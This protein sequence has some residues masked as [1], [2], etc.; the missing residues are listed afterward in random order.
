MRWKVKSPAMDKTQR[1]SQRLGELEREYRAL[2]TKALTECAGGRWG[3]FG[4]NEHVLRLEPPELAE[5]R[6]L[7]ET[8]NRVRARIGEPPFPLHQEFESKRGPRANSN[9]LGESKQAQAWLRRLDE[10]SH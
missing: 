1:L 7:A 10:E 2:L 3:L 8:I 5:L 4:H 9:D 6:D